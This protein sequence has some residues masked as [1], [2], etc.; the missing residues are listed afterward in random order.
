ML[1]LGVSNIVENHWKFYKSR[2]VETKC[3]AP[4]IIYIKI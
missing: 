3:L 1:K 2:H 4:I